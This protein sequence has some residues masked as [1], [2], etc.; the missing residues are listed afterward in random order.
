MGNKNIP[1]DLSNLVI[2]C[3][4]EALYFVTPY[5]KIA[6]QSSR[7]NTVVTN[8]FAMIIEYH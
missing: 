4:N 3:L 2:I 1:K 5:S 6:T 7:C 8:Q